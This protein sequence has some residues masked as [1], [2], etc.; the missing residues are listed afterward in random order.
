MNNYSYMMPMEQSNQFSGYSNRNLEEM[1]PDVYTELIPLIQSMMDRFPDNMPMNEHMLN[2][3]VEEIVD[4]L[5]PDAEETDEMLTDDMGLSASVMAIPGFNNR[6]RRRSRRHHN[7][8][9]L[10]DLTRILLL[11]DLIGRRRGRYFY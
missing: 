2:T 3:M 11:R 7:R 6:R 9:T 8:D 1:Y 4:R 5:G 10:R